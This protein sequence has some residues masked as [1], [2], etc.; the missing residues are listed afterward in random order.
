MAMEKKDKRIGKLLVN[1][2][3]SNTPEEA[4][5]DM[6]K[7]IKKLYYKKKEVIN[8]IFDNSYE[9]KR[10]NIKNL[11]NEIITVNNLSESKLIEKYIKHY[12]QSCISKILLNEKGKIKTKNFLRYLDSVQYDKILT[13]IIIRF[14]MNFEV[15]KQYIHRCKFEDCKRYFLSIQKGPRAKTCIKCRHKNTYTDEEYLIY[16]ERRK[17]KKYRTKVKDEIIDFINRGLDLETIKV[18]FND[19]NHLRKWLDNSKWTIEQAYEGAM[20]MLKKQNTE[21]KA[22]TE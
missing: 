22:S 10:E 9:E 18:P 3:N 16:H 20:K 21:K 1:F 11:L 6:D 8:I 12:N 15:N 17:K 14:L 4:K 5:K 19:D 7:R 13:Y 2:A